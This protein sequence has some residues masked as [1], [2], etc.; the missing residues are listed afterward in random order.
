MILYEQDV[1]RPNRKS[2]QLLVD[3]HLVIFTVNAKKVHIYRIAYSSS[4]T[5]NKL[6]SIT[7]YFIYELLTLSIK[8]FRLEQKMSIENDSAFSRQFSGVYNS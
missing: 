1:Q 5:T 6:I 8:R 2:S 4:N 7:H 3:K